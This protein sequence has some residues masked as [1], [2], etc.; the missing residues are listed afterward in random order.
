MVLTLKT[1]IQRYYSG[2]RS[3]QTLTTIG[4]KSKLA[5]LILADIYD[6]YE[7]S[8]EKELLT[9]LRFFL[10]I[11]NPIKHIVNILNN[12][13]D[14]GIMSIDDSILEE[15]KIINGE[16]NTKSIKI[17]LLKT[18]EDI[19]K[20]YHFSKHNIEIN[21]VII[22]N[23]IINKLNE[24]RIFGNLDEDTRN[25]ILYHDHKEMISKI[26]ERYILGEELA[27]IILDIYNNLVKKST[28]HN[29][30]DSIAS[31]VELAISKVKSELISNIE[32]HIN[33]IHSHLDHVGLTTFNE[34]QT[35]KPIIEEITSIDD[36]RQISNLNNKGSFDKHSHGINRNNNRRD[37]PTLFDD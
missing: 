4:S 19:I 27:S 25:F 34:I 5:A 23:E 15:Y 9:E 12:C 16:N 8:K 14:N 36:R 11:S 21:K 26:I 35:I 3:G 28:S 6:S 31:I 10:S 20:K 33:E 7:N 2:M 32:E 13:G 24:G 22:I 29:N 18:I 17:T 30:Q 1:I 37:H